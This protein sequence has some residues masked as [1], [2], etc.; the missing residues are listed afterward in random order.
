MFERGSNM[1]V[2]KKK[3]LPRWNSFCGLSCEVWEKLNLGKVVEID[4][5]PKPAIPFL[6]VVKKLKEK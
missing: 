1:K 2:K 3:D 4:I 6:K 5:I